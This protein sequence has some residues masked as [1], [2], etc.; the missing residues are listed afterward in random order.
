MPRRRLQ[1]TTRTSKRNRLNRQRKSSAHASGF[2]CTF[3]C[4]HCNITKGQFLISRFMVDV[5]RRQ[6][7]FFFLFLNLNMVLSNKQFGSKRALLGLTKLTS[8]SYLD[9]DLNKIVL[10]WPTSC[11]LSW[12]ICFS[13]ES[14]TSKALFLAS[15]LETYET[16]RK[17]NEKKHLGY[18]HTIPVV[19]TLR[20]HDDDYNLQRERQ[21]ATGWIGKAKALHMYQAFFGHFFCRHCNITTGKFLIS[22]F[23]EDVSD[24]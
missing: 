18:I 12:R 1:S 17:R 24:S 23:N 20:C 8:W 22:R 3:F 4:R 19:R 10:S 7:I 14:C 13:S 15:I 21:K 5:N 6:L 11:S 9:R 16:N 2:F